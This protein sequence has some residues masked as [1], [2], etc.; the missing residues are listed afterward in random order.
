VKNVY[1]LKDYCTCVSALRHPKKQYL[2]YKCPS[3]YVSI[4]LSILSASC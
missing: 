1:S 4:C 3:I 2:I